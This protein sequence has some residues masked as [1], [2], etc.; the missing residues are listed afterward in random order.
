MSECC[1]FHFR[2]YLVW[3]SA[4]S[5]NRKESCRATTTYS[6]TSQPRY[7]EP[8]HSIDLLIT[9]LS[10]RKEKSSNRRSPSWACQYVPPRFPGLIWPSLWH[11]HSSTSAS[12]KLAASY[13]IEFSAFAT[14]RNG[15]IDRF[16][17]IVVV[18]DH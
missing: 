1:G 16:N 10:C 8:L 6:P 5:E 2:R 3:T 17:E 7:I 4:P 13:D 9:P 14:Y 18:I 15:I 11:C 12:R